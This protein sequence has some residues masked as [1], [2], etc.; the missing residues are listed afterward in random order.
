MNTATLKEARQG[1][2]ELDPLMEAARKKWA[3]DPV[4]LSAAGYHKKNSYLL[5]HWN[6]IQGGMAPNDDLLQTASLL[7]CDSLDL[8]PDDPE[9]LNGLGSVLILR[10]DLSAAEFFVRSAIDR[11]KADNQTYP[12]AEEDLK[13]ILRLK[14]ARE[15]AWRR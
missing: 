6:E 1:Q 13:L 11:M 10:R 5:K 7:F 12:A 2:A 4:I 8:Q 3:D 14:G 9:A 15:K